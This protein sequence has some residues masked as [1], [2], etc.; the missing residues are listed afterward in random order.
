MVEVFKFNHKNE[1]PLDR[2][3]ISYQEEHKSV[4]LSQGSNTV[5][6]TDINV[7]QITKTISCGFSNDFILFLAAK[8][9]K[10]PTKMV[11]M[12]DKKSSK[13]SKIIEN[14]TKMISRLA[15]LFLRI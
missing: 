14:V 1:V 9:Q 3:I 6:I 15:F 10:N 5:V 2:M 12:L 8:S 4:F 13:S 11:K 7:N